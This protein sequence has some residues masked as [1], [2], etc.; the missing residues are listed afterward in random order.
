M[1]HTIKIKRSETAGAT[2][3]GADLSTHE[4]AMNVNDGKIYTKAAN[5]SIE[6]LM[7]LNIP[8]FSEV[9]KK[10]FWWNSIQKEYMEDYLKFYV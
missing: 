8:D 7:W 6:E 10:S 1:A 4:I 3:S 2:P 5:G 9:R